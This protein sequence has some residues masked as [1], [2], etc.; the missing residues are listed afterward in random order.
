MVRDDM[1]QVTNEEFD[2]LVETF[3]I[4]FT[5]HFKDNNS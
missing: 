5:K 1:N 2:K 3:D 4:S